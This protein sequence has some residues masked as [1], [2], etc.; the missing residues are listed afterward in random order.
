MMNNGSLLKHTCHY[1]PV[2]RKIADERKVITDNLFVLITVADEEICLFVM[3][4]R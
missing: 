1:N 3:V 2:K 4:F